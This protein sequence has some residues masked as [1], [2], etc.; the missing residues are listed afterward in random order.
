M[1]PANLGPSTFE[2]HNL[3]PTPSCVPLRYI[4]DPVRLRFIGEGGVKSNWVRPG[5]HCDGNPENLS[6]PM[7]RARAALVARVAPRLWHVVDID[8]HG[9]PIDPE[10][11]ERFIAWLAS[12]YSVQVPDELRAAPTAEMPGEASHDEAAAS[13]E[14]TGGEPAG[15]APPAAPADVPPANEGEGTSET[16]AASD[17][18]VI[19]T[20]PTDPV[21]AAASPP[22]ANKDAG[23][24]KAARRS[25]TASPP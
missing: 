15:A 18:T 2:L 6:Q 20:P 10:L 11:R 21:S 24:S 1:S 25:G 8:A 12:R 17:A 4:V 16:T 22:A 14:G 19:A 3:L 23:R 7:P 9:L 5:V 13:D